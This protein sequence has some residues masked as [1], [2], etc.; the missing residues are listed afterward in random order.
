MKP[1]TYPYGGQAVMEGVMMR[2]AHYMSIAVRKTSNDIV[3]E[4][5]PVTQWGEVLGFLKWP[6]IRGTVNLID[7][8]IMGIKALTYSAEQ[9]VEGEGTGETIS[10]FEMAISVIVAMSLAIGLFFLLPAAL[11]YPIQKITRIAGLQNVIEGLLRIAFFLAYVMII[12]RL[13]DIQR[14]FQYHGAEHKVIYTMESGED[15]TVENARLHSCLHPRCGTSFLLIVMIISILIFS[16]LG[17]MNLGMRLL[18]RLLLL[19]VVAGVSY[20]FLRF[21]G[22]HRNH[23][24]VAW[25]SWPGLQLQR[26]TTRP[27]DDNQLEVAIVA[28]NRV[29][30]A[31]GE[32]EGD[33]EGGDDYHDGAA[34]SVGSPL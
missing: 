19:P 32:L 15:I 23:P 9:A 20:E 18:S 31:E 34:Q 16:C 13:K 2:G 29:L 25:L 3:I 12:S 11:S 26:L 14:V 17:Q 22:K 4:I 8:L 33:L 6:L 27:P 1:P 5:W 10:G 7:S 24:V 30:E 28:L 21:A